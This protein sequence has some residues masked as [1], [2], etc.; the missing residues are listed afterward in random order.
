[1][2]YALMIVFLQKFHRKILDFCIFCF[3]KKYSKQL[4]Q[5]LSYT[6]FSIKPVYSGRDGYKNQHRGYLYEN[7][8]YTCLLLNRAKQRI[9]K[10]CNISSRMGTRKLLK[11]PKKCKNLIFFCA[12]FEKIRSS[13]HISSLC[14]SHQYTVH[15]TV[16]PD[17]MV[18]TALFR[19]KNDPK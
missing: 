3:P 16:K 4:A 17:K 10:I 13:E 15:S 19:K 9:T 5:T 6:R 1:M 18:K 12:T 11:V 14:H 2:N 8:S 7:D